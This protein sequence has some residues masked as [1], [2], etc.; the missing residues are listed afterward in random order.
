MMKQVADGV[1]VRQ[2]EWV[3][4]NST[5][6]RVDDGLILVDPGIDGADLNALADEIDDLGLP[7]IAG[8]STHLHWDHLLWHERFGD[9]PCGTG[10]RASRR[11]CR[12]RRRCR[13]ARTTTGDRALRA[14][15]RR[16]RSAPRSPLRT[17]PS[18]PR[19]S[20]GAAARPG[21]APTRSHGRRAAA[22]G[23]GAPSTAASR[24]APRRGSR[25]AGG[26]R[27]SSAVAAR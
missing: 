26:R 13:P 4:S 21:G 8:F 23:A 12:R 3:W 20:S 1:W 14:G 10:A 17:R 27:R 7:V 11:G 9:V 15:T 6:V 18:R 19:A 2:S 24:R 25:P 16:P 5:V 22:R